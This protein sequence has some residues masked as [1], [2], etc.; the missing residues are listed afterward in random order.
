[1]HAMLTSEV[2]Q[3][4]LVG[5]DVGHNQ[6]FPTRSQ[7]SIMGIFVTLFLGAGVQWWKYNH[8]THH[9]TPNSDEHDPDIQVC[10]AMTLSH[11]WNLSWCALQCLLQ[12]AA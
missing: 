4:A 3:L 12:A 2:V 10:I 7:N 11:L 5:H 1:M 9:V 6:L 8:N